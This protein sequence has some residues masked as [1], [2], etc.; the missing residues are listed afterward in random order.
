MADDPRDPSAAAAELERRLD[1]R[2]AEPELLRRALEHPSFTRE[3][4]REPTL[5]NERLEFLGDAVIQLVISE[6]LHQSWPDKL[7][8]ELSTMRAGVVR[9]SSLMQAAEG[10]GL[11]ELVRLGKHTGLGPRN[12]RSILSSA[13]EAVIGAVFLDQGWETARERVLRLLAEQLTAASLTRPR[14]P[15]GRLQELTQE[16]ER[17]TPTYHLQEITGPPH[18]REFRVEVRLGDATLASG[19]GRSKKEAEE[20]AA[21]QAW[22]R[23]AADD[24]ATSG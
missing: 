18:A 2:F 20:L 24:G 16:R 10:L 15:K 7:E 14:N 17:R 4:E 21:E 9:A 23:L 19:V 12:R 8:G 13:F 1:L 3:R 6:H 22:R 5:A 11:A